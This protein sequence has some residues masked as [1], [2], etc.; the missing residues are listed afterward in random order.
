MR[1]T[2][3]LVFNARAGVA[4]PKLLDG[5]LAYLKAAGATVFAVPARGAEEASARVSELAES[6]GADAVIA[7]GGD[8]TFR[9]VATGAAGSALL[10]CSIPLG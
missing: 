10:S 5:V 7:A 1:K 2:F 3:G 6:N 4:R 9:A 8:G